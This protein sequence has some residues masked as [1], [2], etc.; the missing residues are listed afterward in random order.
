MGQQTRGQKSKAARNHGFDPFKLTRHASRSNTHSDGADGTA[1]SFAV[2][3]QRAVRRRPDLRR[4]RFCPWRICEQFTLHRSVSHP[5][6]HTPHHHHTH[7]PSTRSI[8]RGGPVLFV[9][10]FICLSMVTVQQWS[11]VSHTME[12]YSGAPTEAL[13]PLPLPFS[14]VRSL[15]CRLFTANVALGDQLCRPLLLAVKRLTVKTTT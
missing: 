8:A 11:M 12:L 2:R 15:H 13:S 7:P 6:A 14:S 3:K 10:L 5:A 9:F 4:I 1:I